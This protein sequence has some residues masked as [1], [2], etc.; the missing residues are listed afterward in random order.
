M[1]NSAT[2]PVAALSILTVFALA[3][4]VFG[5]A[6][7]VAPG[8]LLSALMAPDP[9]IFG[10]VYLHY[11]LFPRLFVALIC[12][13]ALGLAGVIF[14]QVLKNPLAE[15]ATLGL[16]SGAQLAI[17]VVSLASAGAGGLWAREL[18]ALVGAF[19]ALGLVVALASGRNFSPVTLLLAGMVISFLAGATIVVLSL[20]HHD[21]LRAVFIWASGSLLQDD[22]SAVPALAL[23]LVILVPLVL[24]LVRP[25]T[26]A[27]LDDASAKSL[28]L[29]VKTIRLAALLLASAISAVVVARVGV[30]A[31]VGLAAPH[32]A[33]RFGARHFARRLLLAPLFGALLLAF[34]DGAVLTM[35]RFIGEVPTGTLTA[36]SGAVLLLILLKRLPAAAP[37]ASEPHIVQ[38]RRFPASLVLTITLLALAGV[39]AFSLSETIFIDGLPVG[40][41]AAG[42]WPRIAASFGAGA[43]LALAGVLMQ[44]MTG[45]PLASPE[46][47]GVSAGAGLG[48]IGAVLVAG[49]FSPPVMLV[50]GI[51][52]AGVTFVFILAVARACAWSPGPVLLAGVAVGTFAAALISLV[53]AS[54]DPR[55][56]Y[57]L[58]WSVGPTF[59]ATA[60]TGL[61]ALALSLLSLPFVPLFARWLEILPLGN[62]SARALGVSPGR[63]RALMMTFSAILTAAA[64]LVVGPLSFVGLMAPHMAAML[65][66]GRPLARAFCAVMLGALL[67]VIAD[68]LG[69]SVDFPYEIPAGVLAAFV[70]GPYFLWLLYRR[71]A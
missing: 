47:L 50:G 14:Q 37:Q 18:A 31:F 29:P 26:I 36:I 5:Y 32:F 11:G 22:F 66:P 68:W 15:P 64:T 17:I 19:A 51:A 70:G 55:A 23:R 16:L 41:L 38:S 8:R 6:G 12:G 44:A 3:L 1:R 48:I 54:G 67:M 9:E 59:R 56:A 27:G 10:E 4:T 2:A 7:H 58:A 35:A 30:I 28:G 62:E 20:F 61:V 43:M 34:A 45:N 42:R 69:R 13:A 65:T 40:E 46:S 57:I 60:V 63:A 33:S 21:Y 52:G 71:P 24:L 49:S 25:L 53:L 39:I